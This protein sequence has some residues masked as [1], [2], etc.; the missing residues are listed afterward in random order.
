MR[1]PNLPHFA[2]DCANNAVCQAALCSC[3]HRVSSLSKG[4]VKDLFVSSTSSL[5]FASLPRLGLPYQRRPVI[6]IM[7]ANWFCT[8]SYRLWSY[9]GAPGG[10]E[11]IRPADFLLYPTKSS[12]TACVLPYLCQLT[13]RAIE[14]SHTV[15]IIYA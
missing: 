10:L 6:P 11:A 15:S 9:L 14:H 5:C 12:C 8:R 2:L 13:T 4:E 7:P 3:S 1:T